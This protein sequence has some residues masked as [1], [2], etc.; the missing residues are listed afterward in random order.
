MSLCDDLFIMPVIP[1]CGGGLT[2]D[3]SVSLLVSITSDMAAS[4]YSSALRATG[5]HL[6]KLQLHIDSTIAAA[7]LLHRD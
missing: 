7:S 4:L 2:P 1:V 3:S 6:L 5:M